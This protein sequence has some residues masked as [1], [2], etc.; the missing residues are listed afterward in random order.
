MGGGKPHKVLLVEDDARVLDM[1]ARHLD[2]L[3]YDVA[4]VA[5][6]DEARGRLQRGETP[7]VVIIDHDLGPADCG[8]DLAGEIRTALPGTVILGMSGSAVEE[9]FLDAGADGF[10]AKPFEL[11]AL[12]RKIASLTKP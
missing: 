8:E 1:L 12:S 2:T 7:A 11:G 4:A 5:S 3:G 10:V 6:S 9:R